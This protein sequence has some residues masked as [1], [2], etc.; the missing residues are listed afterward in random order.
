MPD[1]FVFFTVLY[2]AARNKSHRLPQPRRRCACAQPFRRKIAHAPFWHLL[3]FRQ[4][5]IYRHAICYGVSLSDCA[6][7]MR[8]WQLN[9]LLRFLLI[10][11]LFFIFF[12]WF[13]VATATLCQSI[14]I[15]LL[16]SKHLNVL[17]LCQW[18]VI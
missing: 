18:V 7:H 4:S 10:L 17:V 13:L 16:L 1:M 5:L 6:C 15:S 14:L 11:F 9:A 8:Q 2:L 3:A 12:F